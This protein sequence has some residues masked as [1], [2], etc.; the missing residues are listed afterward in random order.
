MRAR[1]YPHKDALPQTTYWLVV[2]I[3]ADYDRRAA[4]LRKNELAQDT[5]AKFRHLNEAVDSALECIEDAEWRTYLMQDIIHKR[6][7]AWSQLSP[8]VAK[9]TYYK[10]KRLVAYRI[11]QSL[12]LI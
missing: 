5:A 4:A 6:G 8:F 11:A 3:C 1:L 2:A 7:Y 10:R 9:N 12:N